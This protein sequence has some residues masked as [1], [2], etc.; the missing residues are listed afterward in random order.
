MEQKIR[1]KAGQPEVFHQT[2]EWTPSVHSG[3]QG[4]LQIQGIQPTL[5]DLVKEPDTG[6]YS[7]LLTTPWPHICYA[8]S[9]LE[10]LAFGITA[11]VVVLGKHVV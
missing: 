4:S 3:Q 6:D 1:H 2:W 8:G 9:A 5:G 10:K 11:G 7:G